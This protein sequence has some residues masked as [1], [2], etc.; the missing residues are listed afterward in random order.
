MGSF[1]VLVLTC[2]P[3]ETV[4]LS[5][6]SG[7]RDACIVRM[8]SRHP[9]TLLP[10]RRLPWVRVSLIRYGCPQRL[11][12]PPSAQLLP[13][14]WQAQAILSTAVLLHMKDACVAHHHQ[15]SISRGFS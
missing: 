9:P 8:R 4:L 13:R 3:A 12:T 1:T 14:L 2:T 11:R 15:H 6:V 7:E 10:H 5:L